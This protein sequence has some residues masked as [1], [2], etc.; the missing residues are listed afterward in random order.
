MLAKKAIPA[1]EFQ[2]QVFPH[3]FILTYLSTVL[4]VTIEHSEAVKTQSLSVLPRCR[5]IYVV[6]WSLLDFDEC[7]TQI[8]Y[9]WFSNVSYHNLE[10]P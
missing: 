9:E 4:I 5:C 10:W 2:L 7:F 6:R 3:H 1:Q 8:L